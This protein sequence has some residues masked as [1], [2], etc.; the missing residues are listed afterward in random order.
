MAQ[1][2]IFSFSHFLL[3]SYLA[4]HFFPPLILLP[5]LFIFPHPPAA[6][7]A[8]TTAP[9]LSFHRLLSP[10]C[11]WLLL[12][13]GCQHSPYPSFSHSAPCEPIAPLLPAFHVCMNASLSRPLCLY[14]GLAPL[15]PLLL[16]A[17]A[18][19]P[20]ACCHNGS[21]PR[22]HISCPHTHAFQSINLLLHYLRWVATRVW[23][24]CAA[25]RGASHIDDFKAVEARALTRDARRSLAV[26]KGDFQKVH[27]VHA[28]VDGLR[29]H[30]ARACTQW[31]A[32]HCNAH[33]HTHSGV[34]DN[35]CVLSKAEGQCRDLGGVDGGRMSGKLNWGDLDSWAPATGAFLQKTP[36]ELL[37]T[38][39]KCSCI[40]KKTQHYFLPNPPAPSPTFI[41]VMI[42]QGNETE[43]HSPLIMSYSPPS[44]SMNLIWTCTHRNRFLPPCPSLCPLPSTEINLPL[45]LFKSIFVHN[46]PNNASDPLLSLK[47]CCCRNKR[48]RST[49]VS[50]RVKKK[51]NKKK[52]KRLKKNLLQFNYDFVKN[53]GQWV[54]EQ[55]KQN[56]QNYR[57]PLLTWVLHISE[58]QVS[59]GIL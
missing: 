35:V 54:K 57:I 1:A 9:A 38:C 37:R 58:T 8:A 56:M 34:K 4:Q 26:A 27:P 50:K 24:V 17:P 36:S 18:P 32:K 52:H 49:W 13:S 2:T 6:A 7:V 3:S 5:S 30:H 39:Y 22:H 23:G 45:Y 20:P 41:R 55:S 11:S 29:S 25:G 51:Q 43:V 31:T 14:Y 44:W 12:S 48:F 40:V 53:R 28:H 47:H 15:P 33:T 16:P 42:W 21:Q 59:K 10:Q 46:K 19:W